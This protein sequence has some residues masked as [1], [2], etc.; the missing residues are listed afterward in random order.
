[1]GTG[2][3]QALRVGLDDRRLRADQQV[4]EP[5]GDAEEIRRRRL[6]LEADAAGFADAG[7]LV[8]VQV[9]GEVALE[10][11]D[12]ADLELVVPLD[13]GGVQHLLQRLVGGG[14]QHLDLIRE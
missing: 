4:M 10:L 11:G 7:A 13:E 14:L 1:E 2:P 8:W 5:A 3:E 12:L 9:T 6:P